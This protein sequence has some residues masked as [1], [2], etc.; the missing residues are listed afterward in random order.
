MYSPTTD[1]PE[2]KVYG[3]TVGGYRGRQPA[4]AEGSE[5]NT[6]A[7]DTANPKGAGAVP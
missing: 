7:V 3:P 5:G 6:A 1:S 4:G 2:A